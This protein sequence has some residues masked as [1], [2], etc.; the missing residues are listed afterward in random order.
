LNESKFS[1]ENSIHKEIQNNTSELSIDYK[2]TTTI[3]NSINNSN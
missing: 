1:Q 3:P 2:N